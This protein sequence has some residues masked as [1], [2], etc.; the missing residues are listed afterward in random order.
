[1][2]LTAELCYL[3]QTT[4]ENPQGVNQPQRF[5]VTGLPGNKEGILVH[6]AKK[7]AEWTVK[8]RLFQLLLSRRVG[9]WDI[10]TKGL[11]L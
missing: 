2:L 1:M 8:R 9:N 6:E 5:D 3:P 10:E 11:K 4:T 7:V